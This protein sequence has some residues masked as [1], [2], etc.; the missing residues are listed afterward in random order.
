MAFCWHIFFGKT[1]K[2]L[3]GANRAKLDTIRY[4]FIAYDKSKFDDEKT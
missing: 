3:R 2:I 1:N 4:I